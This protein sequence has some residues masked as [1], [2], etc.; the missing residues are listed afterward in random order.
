MASRNFD[1]SMFGERKLPL[2][3]PKLAEA[4]Q[5]PLFSRLMSPSTAKTPR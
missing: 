1:W 5:K 3:S 4:F 2:V